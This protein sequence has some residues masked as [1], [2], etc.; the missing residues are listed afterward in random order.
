MALKLDSEGG[1]DAALAFCKHFLQILRLVKL[2][3]L[4]N[5]NF[6]DPLSKFQNVV[7][8]VTDRMGSARLQAEDGMLYFNKDPVRGGRR[9]FGIIQGT[10][11]ALE[12]L[13]IAEL[14]FMGAVS[15]PELRSFFSFLKRP[16]GVR[17][18]D[19]DGVK[20]SLAQANLS[21]RI[22]VFMPG[23][24]T[25]AAQIQQVEIDE[26]T[27]FPLAYARTLVLL[28]EYV[29]NLSNEELNRYFTTKLHRA[30]QELVRLITKY[31]HKFLQMAAVRDVDDYLFNHMANVG[32]LAMLLGNRLGI[33]RLKLSNL[34]LGGMLHA[35][36]TF[37]SDRALWGRTELS[38]NEMAALGKHPYRAIS[39][40]LEGRKITRKTLASC[41]TSFQW[42]LHRGV[43]AL[44]GAPEKHPFA[45]I[46]R[47][48]EEYDS[49]TTEHPDRGAMTP[50]QAL[51]K[52]VEAPGGHFDELVLTVFTNMMGLFPTGTTVSLSSG[53]IAVVVHP[54]PEKPK[55]PLVAIVMGTDGVMLDGD[56]LDLAEKINGQYPCTI[57]GSVDPAE[58]GINV[59]D[60]LLA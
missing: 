30:L 48:V 21:D 7:V 24:T 19:V 33:S 5:V 36:G 15:V 56:F 3:E 22:S 54:N 27:Y 9:A 37:R 57:T 44:R 52:M 32:I 1:E 25:G 41:A 31:E 13:G 45:M 23:E 4:D 38:P 46:V 39:A 29:K 10:D 55:R 16:D 2:Y 59:P 11:K 49:L 53:E 35:L 34:A 17:E 40:I 47:V 12:D 58:L 14:A 42:D 18:L 20:K 50:D 43:T 28:R 26:K 60:Y 6:T 51:R 8:A